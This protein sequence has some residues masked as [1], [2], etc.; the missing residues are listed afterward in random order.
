MWVTW[1]RPTVAL[2]D[3]GTPLCQFFTGTGGAGAGVARGFNQVD[4]RALSSAPASTKTYT[5]NQSGCR[6]DHAYGGPCVPWSGVIHTALLAGL[7]SKSLVRY[8]CG[9]ADLMSAAR[10]FTSRAHEQEETVGFG[11]VGDQGTIMRNVNGGMEAYNHT[12]PGAIFVRDQM[13]QHS[14]DLSFV[15][16]FGDI[17]YANGNQPVWDGYGRDMDPLLSS[18]PGLMSPGNHDGEFEFGNSYWRAGEG[19]GDSGVSYALRFPGPGPRVRFDSR[20]TG[21]FD[22]SSLYWSVD[23]GPVHLVATAGVL[24]F[25]PGTAQYKW[26]EADLAKAAAPAARLRRPWIIVTDHYPLYCSLKSC[27]TPAAERQQQWRRRRHVVEEEGL[28]EPR[29]EPP[30]PPPCPTAKCEDCPTCSPPYWNRT[31]CPSDA[32]PNQCARWTHQTAPCPRKEPA[33]CSRHRPAAPGGDGEPGVL[34]VNPERMR[35]AL[36]PLLLRYAVD[37]VFVGHNHNYER[38][39]AVANLTVVS[40]GRPFAAA[41]RGGGRGG[42]LYEKPGAPIHW[43]VGSGGA[44]PDPTTAW[45]NVS[46]TWRNLSW[47]AT[48]LYDD[49][50]E[51]KNWG[52]TKVVANASCM[53]VQ[54]MDSFHDQSGLDEVWITK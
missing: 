11:L 26:L 38:T 41:G 53:N 43:V 25:E 20:H 9:T 32:T 54:F 19:G 16:V 10:N 44:D 14:A 47:V 12:Y 52:W 1:V 31:Y 39:H 35:R 48:Q 23:S 13:I 34:K 22:S 50:R 45:K 30:L 37:A 7:P 29:V 15:H 5:D 49:V 8:R 46:S 17:A 3:A 24:G 42:T 2:A 40:R 18:V 28:G 33:L 4:N 51:E 21:A 27:N 6:S 36:E